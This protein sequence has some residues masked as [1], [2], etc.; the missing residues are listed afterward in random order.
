[1]ATTTV[2]DA[3]SYTYDGAHRLLTRLDQAR[4][5]TTYSYDR[6]SRLTNRR[7]TTANLIL[8]ATTPG[9]GTSDVFTYDPASRLLTGS[10]QQY[11]TVVIRSYTDNGQRAGLLTSEAQF[12]AGRLYTVRYAYDAANRPVTVVYPDGSV[13]TRT[14][15]VRNQLASVSRNGSPIAS[16][17]GY[18]AGMRRTS[19]VY[20][21]GLQETR[22]YRAD[23]LV[24]TIVTPGVTDFSY[25]YDANKNVTQEIN[26]LTPA[27]NQAFGF[28]PENR[29]TQWHRDGQESQQW[30][31]TLVGDWAATTR[32]GPQAYSQT[33]QH[34]PV[35]EIASLTPA[36][37]ASEALGYDPRG[38]L[39]LDPTGSTPQQ[40]TWDTENRLQSAQVGPMAATYVYDAL[41]RRLAKAA[42]GTTRIFIHDGA[43]VIAEYT[44][45]TLASAAIGTP[46][47]IGSVV[48][49]NGT[50]TVAGAG[51]DIWGA[52]DQCQYAYET[53][54]EHGSMTICLRSQTDTN[55]WAKTG[56]MIRN[57]LAPNAAYVLLAATPGNGVV[58]QQRPADGQATTSTMT[59]LVQYS[60]P[61]WLRLT[62]S[63]PVVLASTSTNGSN[64]VSGA[65]SQV[66]LS[67]ISLLGMA[68]TSHAMN[69]VST[70]IG[71]DPIVQGWTVPAQLPGLDK[72]Y[73]YGTYVDEPLAIIGG[74]GGP[75]YTQYLHSNRVCSIAAL[76]DNSGTVAERYRYDAYGRQTVL[77]ADYSTIQSVSSYGNQVGFTGR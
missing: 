39:T 45:P 30:D 32:T 69:A 64:W 23:N 59:V 40:Y 48:D 34:S 10:S 18:D 68:T 50:L 60:F 49:A 2:P 12:V 1:V 8:D 4:I 66:A 22:T 16:S 17:L 26:G 52:S 73:V 37:Q 19:L 6:A 44:A 24:Q 74:S 31:L 51:S 7:Y 41:G 5:L 56:L 71:N 46:A 55:A 20:G 70:A 25:T 27:E 62:R 21:N 63:G 43:Q 29:V 13:V 53:V 15:T 28:D 38:N 77:A 54:V 42:L 14:Y 11:G 72:S 61:L 75:A 3:R 65:A 47:A 67:P 33:R 35:H 58:L 9:L 76:T 57:S 36:G